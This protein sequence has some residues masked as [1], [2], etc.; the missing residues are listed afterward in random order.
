MRGRGLTPQQLEGQERMKAAKL[1]ATSFYTSI[2]AI[3]G[4]F[5]GGAPVAAVVGLLACILGVVGLIRLKKIGMGPEDVDELSAIERV[6][7][8][9]AR[10]TKGQA[11]LGI[12]LGIAM[13]ALG[14]GMFV[15]AQRAE[16]QRRAEAENFSASIRQH[17]GAAQRV[18]E[19]R[20]N[21][22]QEAMK[23][24]AALQMQTK[25]PAFSP[26]DAISEDEIAERL[27]EFLERYPDAAWANHLRSTDMEPYTTF[28]RILRE[29]GWDG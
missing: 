28:R 1:C 29:H 10:R 17:R 24:L 13:I 11:Q 3:V 12:G 4:F 19:E 7:V 21:S 18:A 9:M 6:S 8:K 20:R 26:K 2:G 27:F 16:D 15:L 14:V 5:V 22:E 23:M 25:T